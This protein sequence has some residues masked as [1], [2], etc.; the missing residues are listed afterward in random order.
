MIHYIQGIGYTIPSVGHFRVWYTIYTHVLYCFIGVCQSIHLEHYFKEEH[1]EQ[2][3]IGEHQACFPL[4]FTLVLFSVGYVQRW[5]HTAKLLPQFD[6]TL[7]LGVF[8]K[9]T[10]LHFWQISCAKSKTKACTEISSWTLNG[11]NPDY[12]PHFPQQEWLAWEIP[13]S[14]LNLELWGVYFIYHI[15]KINT[16]KVEKK[17]PNIW[18]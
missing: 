6:C 13:E 3:A 4:N 2:E 12:F 9:T 17:H 18:M 7:Y 14:F 15:V 16:I 1:A 5:R 10:V 11:R 8:E